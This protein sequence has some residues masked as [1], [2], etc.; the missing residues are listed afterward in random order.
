MGIVIAVFRYLE[1]PLPVIFAHPHVLSG[2][3]MLAVMAAV[4]IFLPLK[5]AGDPT[6]PAPPTAIM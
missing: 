4:F 1:K 3:I 6:E 2:F 5:T